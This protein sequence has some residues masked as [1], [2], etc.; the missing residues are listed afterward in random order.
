M[1]HQSLIRLAIVALA[2]LAALLPQGSPARSQ[3]VFHL[4]KDLD[5]S[6]SADARHAT[7]AI[8]MGGA[9]YFATSDGYRKCE[10]WRTDGTAS[11][12]AVVMDFTDYLHYRVFQMIPAVDRFYFLTESFEYDTFLWVSD[13]TTE[14]THIVLDS[15]TGQPLSDFL[16]YYGGDPDKTSG[17]PFTIIGNQ[18]FIASNFGTI[19]KTDGTTAGTTKLPLNTGINSLINSN[20]TLYIVDHT[21]N[22]WTSDGT[23][24]GTQKLS[25]IMIRDWYSSDYFSPHAT[26]ANKLY[27]LQQPTNTDLTELWA[28]DGTPAGTKKVADLNSSNQYATIA[29]DDN[30]IWISTNFNDTI[31]WTS[32]GTAAGTVPITTLPANMNRDLAFLEGKLYFILSSAEGID[33]WASGGTAGSTAKVATLSAT[34][35]DTQLRQVGSKLIMCGLTTVECWA[36]DGTAAGTTAITSAGTRLKLPIAAQLGSALIAPAGGTNARGLIWKSDGTA[37]G[38]AAITSITLGVGALTH[39]AQRV[40]GATYFVSNGQEIWKSDGTTAGTTL[41]SEL[42]AKI[43]SGARFKQLLSVNGKLIIVTS[44]AFLASDGTAAG[45]VVFKEATD[46]YSYEVFDHRLLISDGASSLWASDGTAAGTILLPTDGGTIGDLTRYGAQMLFTTVKDEVKTL[47]TTNGTAAGTTALTELSSTAATRFTVQGSGIFW[48]APTN[49]H[50]ELWTYNAQERKPQ[51]ITD[52]VPAITVQ[53][54]KVLL[55]GKSLIMLVQSNAE[56]EI[57]KSDGTDTGTAKIRSMQLAL[58]EEISAGDL[59]FFM[60][61]DTAH[62]NELWRT[63]GTVEGTF[64]VKDI[65]PG[66]TSS[67]PDF[68]HAVGSTIY[69]CAYTPATGVELWRSNGTTAGTALYA[70]IAPGP[71]SSNVRPDI[72]NFGTELWVQAATP[73]YGNEPYIVNINVGDERLYLP[74]V[75]MP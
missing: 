47:W 5:T 21:E 39:E 28:T 52:I 32:D 37:A 50:I 46:S 3:D 53:Y 67:Y 4:L 63:D 8:T 59:V 34:L 64:M 44:T 6:T 61:K 1:R 55:A 60:G 69:F 20:G 13:G 73:Q 12:T 15:E 45:T 25:Q 51:Q 19:W 9:T 24:A 49:N 58:G 48:I 62:G 31:L 40:N 54:I 71:Y 11:G 26:F 29:A 17:N 75:T 72:G 42:S 65:N 68:F 2:L 18:L 23:A 7:E 41:Q 27:Y 22:L 30:G 35:Q 43:P 70:D 66:P 74:I 56:L 36:S 14:G 33:L 57:W 16:L 38:T 10:L